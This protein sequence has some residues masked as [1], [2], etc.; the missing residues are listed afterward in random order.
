MEYLYAYYSL[1]LPEGEAGR[2]HTDPW[3]PPER[4]VSELKKTQRIFSAAD[5]VLSV[6]IDEMRHFR[7]VNEML[8][9]LKAPPVFGRAGRIGI[10]DGRPLAKRPPF[11]LEPLT[12]KQLKWF[13]EVEAASANKGVPPSLDGMYTQILYSIENGGGF[14]AAEKEFLSHS[15]KIIIDEGADHEKRFLHVKDALKGLRPA[16]Y[17]RVKTGPKALAPNSPGALL[18]NTVDGAY[19]V[20]LESLRIVFASPLAQRAAMLEAARR[21][22]Y[23][24][25]AACRALSEKRAGAR[26][27]LPP[28][29]RGAKPA[30][31]KGP[32]EMSRDEA[33][34]AARGL[35]GP[36]SRH[37]RR[38]KAGSSRHAALAERLEGQLARMRQEMETAA[39]G[40]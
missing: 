6:A 29:L 37:L 5:T 1:L 3:A 26:F 9:F 25:D 10:D 35:G 30:A 16:S 20:V 13:I 38:L 39:A 23:I 28:D 18:Q 8:Q 15:V 34:D 14:S 12:R 19:A 21:A 17:L 2:P 22:M 24:M 7:W 4:P 31:K 27:Q 33:C 36:L 32:R 40:T 11:T